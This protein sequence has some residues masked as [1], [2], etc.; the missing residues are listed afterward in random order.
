MTYQYRMPFFDGRP[1]HTP[2][3]RVNRSF[4]A[5]LQTT[6]GSP[7][8]APA[9]RTLAGLLAAGLLACSL[10]GGCASGSSAA[11]GGTGSAD[12]SGA[13]AGGA[14]DASG[15]AGPVNVAVVTGACANQPVHSYVAV[16]D[17]LE[18]AVRSNGFADVIVADTSVSSELGGIA[19]V[20][21]TTTNPTRR[22]QEEDAIV[23]SLE[24]ACEAAVADSPQTDVVRA[25]RYAASGLAG[26]EGERVVCLLHSGLSTAGVVDLAETPDWLRADPG[27]LAAS[28]AEQLPDLSAID[29]VYWYDLGY[30]AGNQREPDQVAVTGLERMWEAILTQ[31]GVGAVEFVDSQVADE[32]NPSEYE[33]DPVELEFA[34]RPEVETSALLESGGQVE[35]PESEVGF[36]PDTA[37]FLDEKAAQ[38][39]VA[40]VARVLLAHPEVSVYVTG[41]CAGC[42]WEPDRGVA[43]STQRAQ[44][45]A[46]LLVSMGV[47][48]SRIVVEGVGDQGNERVQHVPDL[49]A[50]G[51]TQTEDA[52]LNRR[53]VITRNDG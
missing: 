13:A 27:E 14:A 17:E 36:V 4:G 32:E 53:V 5:I 3:C 9:R 24:A 12:G 34:A 42:P 7:R 35:I 43:L 52:Q 25:L 47:D 49:A 2:A 26:L 37:A 11:A 29:V 18:R 23:A 41:S 40:Q 46:D 28:L 8:T 39:Y 51:V 20:G 15:G 31:A 50:D 10:L 38:A 6:A 44:A 22:A 45:V 33:V 1:F 16:Q 30:V 19:Q 21:S 48:A